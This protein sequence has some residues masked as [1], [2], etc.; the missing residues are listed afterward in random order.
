MYVHL[1]VIFDSHIIVCDLSLYYVATASSLQA[2]LTASR[3]AAV[4]PRQK[5]CCWGRSNRIAL[6]SLELIS[7]SFKLAPQTRAQLQENPA[8]AMAHRLAYRVFRGSNDVQ[9]LSTAGRHLRLLTSA[10]S[11]PDMQVAVVGGGVVGLAIAR[12][13]ALAGRSVLLLEAGSG[14]G[15]ETSSRSSEVVHAGG[16]GDSLSGMPCSMPAHPSAGTAASPPL[17]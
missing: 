12:E 17:P 14:V 3:L 5:G 4:I 2:L 9:A 11:P 13:L 7:P 15:K 1:Y 10:A 8:Q 16:L 6:K